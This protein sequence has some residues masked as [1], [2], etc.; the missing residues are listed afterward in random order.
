MKGWSVPAVVKPMMPILVIPVFTV[1]LLA[2]LVIFGLGAPIA[3]LDEALTATLEGMQ[4]ANAALLGVILGAMMA[5]DMGG[6]V[7]KVAYVFGSALVAD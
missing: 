3:L 6:P 5:F 1:A 2:P 4:G 7:T